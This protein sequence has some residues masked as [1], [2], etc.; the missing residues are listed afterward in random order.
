MAIA[1]AVAGGGTVRGVARRTFGRQGGRIVAVDR[2]AGVPGGRL[3]VAV[4]SVAVGAAF[5]KLSEASPTLGVGVGV[6]VSAEDG[7]GADI[8][9]VPVV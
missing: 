9:R 7:G 3:A 4:G 8:D 1:G 5:V 2:V 6:G